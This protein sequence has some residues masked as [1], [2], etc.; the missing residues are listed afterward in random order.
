MS[1]SEDRAKIVDLCLRL[2]ARREHSAQELLQKLTARGFDAGL[3]REVIDALQAR[4]WQDDAR[5]VESF[6]RS[7]LQRGHGP[8]KVRFE[9]RGKGVDDAVIE[10]VLAELAPDWFEA[11]ARACRHKFGDG[12]ASDRN[13]Y[14]RR[15]RFLA[16]RGF[17][18]E[19]IRSVLDKP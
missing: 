19:Q 13:E 1:R 15:W 11:A 7:R 9:L 3:T 5:F 8:L 4:G 18:S 17:D 16:Q 12:P 6:V 14:A 10:A 2:L